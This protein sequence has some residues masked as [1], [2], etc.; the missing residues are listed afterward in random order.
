[1]K[2]LLFSILAALGLFANAQSQSEVEVL[3]PQAFI[4][5]VKADTSAIILDVR[6]P[7]EFAEGHLAQAINLDWL[8]QTVFINGLAKLNKQKTYYIYCRSGRRSQAAAG[9]LKAEGFQV[10]DLKG[11]YLHWVELGLPV[12]K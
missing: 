8:N 9:K 1:M 12:V 6:Q 5:R 10:V 11:G 2:K 3:E 7:E 4:E